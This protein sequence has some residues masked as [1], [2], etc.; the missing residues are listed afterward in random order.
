[1]P[2][3]LGRIRMIALLALLPAAWLAAQH[4]MVHRS[5]VDPRVPLNTS[6]YW[7]TT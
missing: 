5:R 2:L 1:M 4:D 6:N 7:I 3:V